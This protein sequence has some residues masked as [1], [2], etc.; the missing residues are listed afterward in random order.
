MWCV[1]RS[2]LYFIRVTDPLLA[3]NTLLIEKLQIVTIHLPSSH[4]FL[5]GVIE[6]S[7]F[8]DKN[9]ILPWKI[10][11]S[12]NASYWTQFRGNWVKYNDL[13]EAIWVYNQI[14]SWASQACQSMKFSWS[15]HAFWICTVVHC[16][17]LALKEELFSQFWSR[18][19][20]P[21]QLFIVPV[22]LI[23]VESL[24]TVLATTTK[25]NPFTHYPWTQCIFTVSFFHFNP[26][27]MR[28][29]GKMRRSITLDDF[30]NRNNLSL[31]RQVS[32][33]DDISDFH[34]CV[35]FPLSCCNMF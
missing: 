35:C 15:S 1:L 2:L 32:S 26:F 7:F 18:E 21:K 34:A 23:E 17:K 13:W 11:C 29:K 33:S 9:W 12:W 16:D 27:K 4:S 25:W 30:S 3:S 20:T 6:F 28:E 31:A 24:T 5:K 14:A 22:V 10:H 19:D 8:S